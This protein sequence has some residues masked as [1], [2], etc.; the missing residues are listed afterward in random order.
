MTEP[1]ID[2][3]KIIVGLVSQTL[4]QLVSSS[5]A[6]VSARLSRLKVGL[7]LGFSKYLTATRDR[8]STIKTLLYRD[9]PVALLDFYVNLYFQYKN[10]KIDDYTVVSRLRDWKRLVITGT[11]GSGKSIFMKYLLISLV[12]KGA[13][14][15]P[16]F[17]ELRHLNSL[18]DKDLLKFIYHTINIH[19]PSLTAEAFEYGLSKGAFALLL[20]GFDEL[21]FTDRKKHE[22]DLLDLSARFPDL[23]IVISSRPDDCFA[24]WEKFHVLEVL[25]M[26][27]EQTLELLRKLDYDAD[28]KKK[29]ISEIKKHLF[30]RHKSFL[31]NPL[32]AT[33][34]LLTF[35]QFAQIPD[36]MHV[37]YE[38][39]F[40]T[41]YLKHDAL[42]ASY[43]RQ[44][45]ANLSIDDFKRIFSTFCLITYFEQ[46]FSFEEVLIRGY[47][48]RAV[49]ISKIEVKVDDF[50]RDLLESVCLIQKDGIYYN[51]SHR[52][53]QEYFCAYFISRSSDSEAYRAAERL[54]HRV[55]DNVLA[56][57]KDINQDLLEEHWI[58]PRLNDIC[59]A[60]EKVDEVEN[61]LSYAT[62]FGDVGIMRF[63]RRD[64]RVSWSTAKQ[65]LYVKY[66]ILN[67][68]PDHMYKF[69]KSRGAG[70]DYKILRE[71]VDSRPW[72]KNER[73]ESLKGLVPGSRSKNQVSGR[74]AS[75]IELFDVKF[76]TQ[77]NDNVWFSKSKMAKR[78]PQEKR[79][80][81]NLRKEVQARVSERKEK[82]RS[83]FDA[84]LPEEG[85][86]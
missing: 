29:F 17:I 35:E 34:M 42:K 30:E 16:V 41:L 72:E 76:E 75:E 20:D 4:S 28:V 56:M 71:L 55:E 25:P 68:Y 33:M 8:A 7:H 81:Q 45:Y 62:I 65:E 61:P 38:Q 37:F 19:V 27:K 21:N 31:S 14:G 43:K 12:T 40:D 47:L 60:I 74:R 23:V 49:E 52:S 9:R 57:L 15:I 85:G 58:L 67:L 32:L 53:F 82:L 36:K 46:V 59:E 69:E 24:S 78:F 1:E 70:N 2:I 3:N 11:A 79:V 50:L 44:T 84:T 66:A 64:W 5:T 26:I 18:T 83:I 77:P 48:K 63:L 13:T 86:N 39:A 10:R 73:Y 54:S 22:R 80:L 51:F 6:A